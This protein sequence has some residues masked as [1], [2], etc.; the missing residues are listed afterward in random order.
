MGT[1]LG[2]ASPNQNHLE[3]PL[4]SLAVDS[5]FCLMAATP[6]T[7]DSDFYLPANEFFRDHRHIALTYDD[8]TLATL[9]SEIL[10]RDTQ[11]STTLAEGLTLNIPII[12][13]D[14]DTVTE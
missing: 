10:P 8:V 12:S 3:S 6:P 4:A 14:M 11:L 5:A 9:Y 7:V 1:A 2:A 13:A